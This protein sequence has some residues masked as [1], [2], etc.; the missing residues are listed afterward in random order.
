MSQ[1]DL[2]LGKLEVTNELGEQLDKQLQQAESTAQQLHGGSL[3]LKAGAEKVGE[4]GIHVTRDLEEGKLEFESALKASE[5]IHRKII[6]AREVLLNLA[7]KSKADELVAHGKAAGLRGFMQTMQNH[8]KAAK[9]RSQQLIAQAEELA[10]ALEEQ[11]TE[12]SA[13]APEPEAADRPRG[14][15][16]GQ[17]PGR[18]PLDERRAEAA[19]ARAEAEAA[20]K[21]AQTAQE[22]E[23]PAEGAETPEPTEAAPA[24][25]QSGGNGKPAKKAPNKKRGRPKKAKATTKKD[26]EASEEVLPWEETGV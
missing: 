16:S 3:A 5:Y 15:M 17:H 22:P 4:L 19:K 10:K 11:P 14:R 23:K 26:P 9:A 8:A 1:L 25:P 13:S 21:A 12:E 24:T 20:E 7:E 6:Q 2:W 18:S